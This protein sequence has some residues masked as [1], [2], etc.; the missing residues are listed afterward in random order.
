LALLQLLPASPQTVIIDGYG[1]LAIMFIGG[2][3]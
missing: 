1:R 2:G 3:L